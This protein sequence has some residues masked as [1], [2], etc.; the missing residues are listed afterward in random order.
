MPVKCHLTFVTNVTIV[1]VIVA[2]GK[3]LFVV[4]Q[5]CLVGSCQMQKEL[6]LVQ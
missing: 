5:C 1:K 4:H 2:A 3:V 6:L